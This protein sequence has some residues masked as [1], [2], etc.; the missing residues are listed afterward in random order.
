MATTS[1]VRPD[2]RMKNATIVTKIV[3][4]TVTVTEGVGVKLASTNDNEVDISGANDNSYGVAL[5]TVVGDGV[6]LV[7]VALLTGG[8]V[9]PVKLSSTATKG[10]FAIAGS[11]G[12]ENQTIGGGTTVKY[13]AGKFEN[14]GVVGDIV[15]L[16]T[17]QFAAGCA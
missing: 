3:K 17:G 7:Q 10:S 5:S 2:I 9:I 1:V 6:K 13:I 12:F 8:A 15:G 14:S 11:G 4:N 16:A